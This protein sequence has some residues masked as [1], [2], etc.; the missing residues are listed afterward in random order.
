MHSINILNHELFQ[1]WKDVLVI[2]SE[3]CDL[4]QLRPPMSIPC[5]VRVVSSKTNGGEPLKGKVQPAHLL[6]YDP[7][8]RCFTFKGFQLAPMLEEYE[9]LLGMPLEKSPPYLFRGHYPSWASV[10]KLLKVPKDPR[11]NSGGEPPTALGRRGLADLHRCIRAS[12]LWH[13]AFPQIEQYVD[14]ATV[15]TFL[16]KRDRG[17]QPVVA[18]LANTYHTLDYWSMKNGRGL[19]CCTSLLFLWL[20]A[21]LFHSSE[22]TRCPIE[23]HR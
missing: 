23:D 21:H 5:G 8:L 20:T 6:Y 7:P 3:N 1:T 17:E 14:L 22:R 18:V 11:S 15:D 10:A 13:S 16:S 19:R 9:R 4:P 2:T 12:S